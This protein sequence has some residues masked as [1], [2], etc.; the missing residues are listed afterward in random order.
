M[1]SAVSSSSTNAC[2]RVQSP[3]ASHHSAASGT[4]RPVGGSAC[5]SDNV[6]SLRFIFA[7]LVYARPPQWPK[8]HGFDVPRGQTKEAAEKSNPE[9]R[10]LK[11]PMKRKR[12][13]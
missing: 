1:P 7:S 5:A 6:D 2:E 8:E 9:P 13:S 4:E 10:G 11:P 3:F 12:L